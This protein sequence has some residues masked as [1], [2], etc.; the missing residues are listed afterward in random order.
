MLSDS[1]GG[2]LHREE[3]HFWFWNLRQNPMA[4]EF[5]DPNVELALL[6]FLSGHAIKLP[7]KYLYFYPQT[8]SALNHREASICS[9]QQPMERCGTDQSAEEIVNAWP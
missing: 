7:S 2:L 8:Y 5:I 9:E 4:G 3:F 6:L 1:M